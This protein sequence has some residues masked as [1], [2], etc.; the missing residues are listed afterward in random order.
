MLSRI[1]NPQFAIEDRPSGRPPFWDARYARNVALFGTA[2][3]AFVRAEAGRIP[4]G[5]E[6]VEVG[7]GEARNLIFLAKER[8]A[9]VT[10]V[11]FA[12]E[13]LHTARRRAKAEGVELETVAADVRRWQPQSKWDAMLV[14]FLHLLPGERPDNYRRLQM[15]LRPGGLLLAEWFSA[16]HADKT[17]FAEIGPSKPDRLISPD[18]LRGHFPEESIELLQESEREIDE[19]PMLKGPAAVLRFAWRKPER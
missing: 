4:K 16:A 17:C 1:Q 7:A 3:N 9:R 2:P 19:G 6:V 10:A 18:E 13:G 12:E 5:A 8:G 15:A 11:D 14:T